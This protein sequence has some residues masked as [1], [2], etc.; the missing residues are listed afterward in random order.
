MTIVMRSR[1]VGSYAKGYR[2]EKRA[3]EF[4]EGEGYYVVESRGSHGTFD[5]VAV[6]FAAVSRATDGLVRLIQVKTGEPPRKGD[7]GRLRTM[8]RKF[9]AGRVL[10]ELWWFPD[11]QT[12][13]VKEVIS[14]D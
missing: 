7:R 8:A 1:R 2:G 3:R 6:P 5:L 11:Y 13:P 9:D 10:C 12:K 4:L 14:W